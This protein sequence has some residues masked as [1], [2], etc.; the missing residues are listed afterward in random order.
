VPIASRVST[1][2]E[3][4]AREFT[5]LSDLGLIERKKNVL[6]VNNLARLAEMVHTATGE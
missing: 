2:R 5:R 6:V 4:V 1:H 3:A